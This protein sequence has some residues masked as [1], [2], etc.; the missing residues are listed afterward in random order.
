MV[1]YHGDDWAAKLGTIEYA[2]ATLVSASTG[3]SPFEVDT[4]RQERNPFGTFPTLS[5]TVQVQQG[6]SEYANRFKDER[7]KIIGKAKEHLLK[8]QASQKKYYDQHRSNVQFKEGD[9]VMLDT[10]RIPLKHAAKDIDVKRAKLAARKVGPFV[11]KRMINDNAA[12]LILPR[13]MKSLNPTFNVDVLSHYVSNPDKF[14]TRVLPKASRIITNE[15]TGEDLHIVEKLLRKRQFNRKIEWLVKWHGLPDHES[16]WELEKDIKHVSHWK[17]LVD[18]F[19]RRQR[20]VK[21]GR[22]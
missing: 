1:S 8:A 11:I 7:D 2:H 5:T 4:G 14:E 10:R 15:D 13:S 12:R 22:M 20:E 6:L 9:L 21:P 16:S 18:D 3:L 19:K 17:V